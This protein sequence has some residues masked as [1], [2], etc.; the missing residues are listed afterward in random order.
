[1]CMSYDKSE[2]SRLLVCMSYDKSE[3]SRLLVCMSYDKSKWYNS[4][5]H[6]VKVG[7]LCSRSR[8]ARIRRRGSKSI[9]GQQG[10][11]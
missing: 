6:D 2:F 3:F 11:N 7:G 4:E 8:W 10:Q 9:C 1:M 5:S